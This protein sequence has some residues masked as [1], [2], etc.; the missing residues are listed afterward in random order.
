M[1]RLALILLAA[2]LLTVGGP[3]FA[4][5]C[6]T[7]AVPAATLLLPYFEVN[8][9]DADAGNTLFSINNASAA[10]ALAHVTLWTN[11]SHPTI[12]FDVFLTGYDVI[13]VNLADVFNGNIPLT[14]DLQS[15]PADSKSPHGGSR[16]DGGPVA[17]SHLEWDGSF[18]NCQNFFPFF[19][20][21]VIRNANLTRLQN[22]H[23]G[24]AVPA[25]G[26]CLG[27]DFGDNIARGYITI[28]NVNEC[29][30]E[31]PSDQTGIPPYFAGSGTGIAS[32]VN[33][34]W[35]DWFFLD[36]T[37]GFAQGDT[38]VH[39]EALDGFDDG[40]TVG[41]IDPLVEDPASGYTF[42]GR[43]VAAG[44][45]NR[46]PLGTTWAAR[47]LNNA[48]FSP[49]GTDFTVWRDSTVND[50]AATQATGYT[51]GPA[52]VLFVG[53]EWHPLNETEVIAFDEFENAVE[54]CFTGA[55]GVISPQDPADDPACF[56]LETQR[57]S[58]TNLAYS[59]IQSP[60]GAGWMFLN[61]NVG[62]DGAFA[63]PDFDP[64]SG[65]TLAQ[66][67]VT[68][69]H[70]A[71]G[72]FSVGLQAIELTSACED[73]DFLVSEWCDPTVPGPCVILQNTL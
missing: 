3:A 70:S 33:Q 53:P 16:P 57:I 68:V 62:V 28:D 22:G 26:G 56:P 9:D 71:N 29:S 66:S 47:Y 51:C 59:G 7:D 34:L 60:W 41:T 44:E 48:L 23:T 17:N 38:L 52:G 65:G 54:L 31:F 30:T 43:Y 24:Q 18:F 1:K 10:P 37:N 39:I 13:Q 42:Y 2:T 63:S 4:E 21:P 58:S 55:S 36:R 5:M 69:S 8:L 6:T 72:L 35:G 64:G 14:A 12:D 50:I 25:L 40:T 20:N 61:L 32:N 27:A 45:D 15:D 19:S 67:H 73:F 11:W 49:G 46:E